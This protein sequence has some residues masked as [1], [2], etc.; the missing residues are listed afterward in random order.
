MSNYETS[1]I[2]SPEVKDDERQL[3]INNVKKIIEDFKGDLLKEDG[4]E[5]KKLAY[6][7]RQFQEGYYCFFAYTGPPGLPKELERRFNQNEKIIRYLTLKLDEYLEKSEKLK[8]EREK[9]ARKKEGI[10]SSADEDIEFAE[11][12]K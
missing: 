6:K 7:I 10:K 5:K 4:W 12:G 1:F 8:R 2:I 9:K 3:I 11:Q